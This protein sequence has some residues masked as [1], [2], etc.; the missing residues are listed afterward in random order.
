MKAARRKLTADYLYIDFLIRPW[1]IISVLVTFVNDRWLKYNYSGFIV[2]KLS[3]FCGLFYFPL[4]LAA[5]FI[6]IHRYILRRPPLAYLPKSILGFSIF[7]TVLLFV[8]IKLYS[9]A[10]TFYLTRLADL[11]IKGSVTRDPSDLMALPSLLLAY[12][13]ARDYC[14]L[15]KTEHK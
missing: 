4:F 13:Y 7:F 14:A 11:G 5:I 10:T 15:R 12:Q 9:P 2:G 3:D 6:M 8:L 1:P